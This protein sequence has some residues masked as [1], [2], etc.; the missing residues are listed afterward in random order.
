MK[1]TQRLAAA[2]VA[3]TLLAGLATMPA[4]ATNLLQLDYGVLTT[5]GFPTTFDFVHASQGPRPCADKPPTLRFTADANGTWTLGGGFSHQFQFPTA[6][7]NWYQSDFTILT[8]SGGGWSGTAPFQPLTGTVG[9]QLRIYQLQLAGGPL[10]CQKTNL[11]CI[12][13]GAFALQPTS[14]YVAWAGP[15]GL[16][17]TTP[18]DRVTIDGS[19][20]YLATS[21]C[22]PPWNSVSA[23]PASI[24]DFDTTVL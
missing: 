21:S 1:V 13:T 7:G 6:S 15:P 9:L 17:T 5:S 24:T 22:A 16:P 12:M 18:G 20:P 2:A 8:G 14:E 23:G 10:L 3:A 19:T 11:R 4:S